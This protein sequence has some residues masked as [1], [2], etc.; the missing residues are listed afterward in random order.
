MKNYK[1]IV[2]FLIQLYNGLLQLF[3]IAL[4]LL[5]CF[6]MVIIIGTLVGGCLLFVA[7]LDLI[8]V[9]IEKLLDKL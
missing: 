1:V 6:I 2:A 3:L 9:D 5:C 4:Y 8:G 7:I